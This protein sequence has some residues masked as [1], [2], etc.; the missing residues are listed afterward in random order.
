M[1]LDTVE[2]FFFVRW[3][4]YY[5]G[6]KVDKKLGEMLPNNPQV[7]HIT[8]QELMQKKMLILSILGVKTTSVHFGTC[9]RREKRSQKIERQLHIP[10]GK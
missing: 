5:Q 10:L 2:A 4:H 3:I 1:S 9:F 8:M 6:L 7:F